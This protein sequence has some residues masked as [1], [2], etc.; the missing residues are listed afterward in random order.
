MPFDRIDNTMLCCSYREIEKDKKIEG[1]RRKKERKEEKRRKRREERKK[2]K[3]RMN[4]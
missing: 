2:E 1:K 3:R 4:E